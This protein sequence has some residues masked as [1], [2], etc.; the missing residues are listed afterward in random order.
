[1][2]N[3]FNRLC[4]TNKPTGTPTHRFS[5][6][7]NSMTPT[8]GTQMRKNKS[9]S[10]FWTFFSNNINNLRDYITSALYNHGIA[11][12]N[13]TPFTNGLS[14]MANSLNIILIMQT[15]IGHHHPTNSNRCKACNRRQSSR[16]T[17]LNINIFQKRHCFFCWKFMGYCPTRRTRNKPQTLLEHQ[18]INLINNAINV[19]A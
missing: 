19:I 7:T 15:G 13:I 16:T 12:T 1:M 11:Y 4:R 2:T 14:F 3:T 17:D 9:R 18:I 5:F 10:I 8:S 6:F